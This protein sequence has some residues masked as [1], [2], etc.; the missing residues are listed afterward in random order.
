MDVSTPVTPVSVIPRRSKKMLTPLPDPIHHRPHTQLERSKVNLAI[1]TLRSQKGLLTNKKAVEHER[2]E[3]EREQS[4][5]HTE[6]EMLL[7]RILKSPS[8][9]V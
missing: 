6:R 4:R 1:L 9:E 5:I 8:P 3:V 7:K 2:L